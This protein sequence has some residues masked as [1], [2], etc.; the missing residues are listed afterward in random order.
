M[1][2]VRNTV[3]ITRSWNGENCTQF[4]H[5]KDTVILWGHMM[6]TSICNQLFYVFYAFEGWRVHCIVTVSE[7]TT[8]HIYIW[9][10]PAQFSGQ[11]CVF[12]VFRHLTSG[13]P[14]TQCD[15]ENAKQG[16]NWWLL[17]CSLLANLI[18]TLKVC[19][20]LSFKSLCVEENVSSEMQDS[21]H[22]VCCACRRWPRR[23][24]FSDN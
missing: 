18:P 24:T 16:Y 21:L 15:A 11:D 7:S 4:L 3:L 6:T 19:V 5:D 22:Y 8:V 1:L 14:V 17:L 20:P 13:I 2:R 9:L 12:I 23:V 10:I